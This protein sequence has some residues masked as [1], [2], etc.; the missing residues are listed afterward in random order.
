MKYVIIQSPCQDPVSE[1]EFDYCNLFIYNALT[2]LWYGT[3]KER[4]SKL[5][6][7]FQKN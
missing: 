1:P 5:S 7:P 2:I 4:G 6:V 3:H